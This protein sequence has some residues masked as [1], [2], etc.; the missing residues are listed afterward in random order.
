MSAATGTDAQ[1][2]HTDGAYYHVPPRYIGLQCIELGKADC[3]TLVW[4]LDLGLLQREGPSV[5][6]GPDWVARGGEHVPC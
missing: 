1:P 4:A 5:L 6:T 2:M 3:P